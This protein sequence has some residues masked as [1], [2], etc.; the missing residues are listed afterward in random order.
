MIYSS[1]K[2]D[3]AS[4]TN[5]NNTKTGNS[6]SSTIGSSMLNV[7]TK[8]PTLRFKTRK[9]WFTLWC[10][11]PQ[12]F[13]AGSLTSLNCGKDGRAS[14]QGCTCP[15]VPRKSGTETWA[16]IRR[17]KGHFCCRGSCSKLTNASTWPKQESLRISYKNHTL[18][19]Q[20][21]PWIG[22]FTSVVVSQMSRWHFCKMQLLFSKPRS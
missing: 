12:W 3:W 17:K 8:L 13:S 5:H 15:V 11:L 19:I 9:Y 4:V 20:H 22:T 1:Q 10:H 16:K 7:R 14:S 2:C 21:T 6:T 18:I